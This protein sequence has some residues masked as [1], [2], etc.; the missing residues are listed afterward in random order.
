MTEKE[1]QPMSDSAIEPGLRADADALLVA[2]LQRGTRTLE[3]GRS[4]VTF[5][6][7][8]EGT[9]ALT[10]LGI[11]V[12]D[13]RDFL[14]SAVSPEDLGDADALVFP[15]I[16]AAVLGGGVAD[17]RGLRALADQEI[18]SIEPE[19][20][21][22]AHAAGTE[23][24]RGFQR[25]AAMIAD[26]LGEA[27]A[28][29][30][31]PEEDP[32]VVG[33]TWGLIACKVPPSPQTGAGVKV[34]VLDS[35]MDQGHPDFANRTIVTET[36]GLPPGPPNPHTTHIVGTA[37]GP[38]APAGATPRYGIGSKTL[39]HL[40]V[41]F[42][43]TGTTTTARVLAGMNW[44]LVN[45]CPVIL[46]ALG[47]PSPVQAAYTAAGTAALNKGCLMI[48]A[49]GHSGG[50]TG[51]PANSPTI[52]SV[53]SLDKT[54]VPSAFSP[55]GKIDIAAP[56]RDVFSSVPRPINYALQSGTSAA[57]AHVAGCAALWAGSSASLR[58]ASLWKKL[59]RTAR[60]LAF[61][62]ARVGAGL[63]QAP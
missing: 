24:L 48:A 20:F 51:A 42:S 11:R 23:Y 49:A 57:A 2:A 43:A 41:V 46:L 12:A 50:A 30:V 28:G 59:Q 60:P 47:S 22:F 13:A 53:A 25:A 1:S 62:P 45:R 33:A 54:L 6:S 4:I 3:T 58:G 27:A 14:D 39:I 61:P 16:G 15:E 17:A 18:E 56:G 36:F 31:D 44:A 38:K 19:F 32:L 35:A 5:R 7:L 8:E 52:M 26:D 29:P 34:A 9:R 37:C 55:V 10:A 63:V 21:A 40:G